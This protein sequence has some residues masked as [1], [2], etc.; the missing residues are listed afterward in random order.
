MSRFTHFFC[1]FFVTE[2]QTP[3]TFCAFRMYEC[4]YGQGDL[5]DSGGQAGWLGTGSISA[6]AKIQSC[7]GLRRTTISY[8]KSVWSGYEI[9]WV[10]L[11]QIH[12][13]AK[14]LGGHLSCNDVIQ[15]CLLVWW[16]YRLWRWAKAFGGQPWRGRR[17]A[18]CDPNM[19]CPA[20]LMEERRARKKAWT[21]SC[22]WELS[23]FFPIQYSTAAHR[24]EF[25]PGWIGSLRI[26]FDHPQSL[27]WTSSNPV[28]HPFKIVHTRLGQSNLFSRWTGRSSPDAMQEDQPR[29]VN[30]WLSTVCLL[31]LYIQP[32]VPPT[33]HMLRHL[34]HTM[35][36]AEHTRL[37]LIAKVW[38]HTFVR[39]WV[40][41][42][43]WCSLQTPK[44]IGSDSGRQS[45]LHRILFVAVQVDLL[46]KFHICLG[47][48]DLVIGDWIAC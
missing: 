16:W 24:T 45:H 17:W 27:F 29:S 46:G 9:H 32:F 10:V 19:L 13:W 23:Q 40:A 20:S 6:E 25:Q 43:A 11:V 1:R 47:L 34:P 41:Q 28:L 2:K 14:V 21:V 35:S 44:S 26:I 48:L 5:G 31:L 42:I 22:D 38:V 8:L 15:I 33:S 30:G 18:K 36:L 39:V 4:V 12:W 37:W 3:K 7:S